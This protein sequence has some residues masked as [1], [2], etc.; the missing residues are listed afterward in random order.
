MRA[1]R[2]CTKHTARSYTSYGLTTAVRVSVCK[3]PD[4]V[5]AAAA[6]LRVAWHSSTEQVGGTRRARVGVL[7]RVWAW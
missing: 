5:A 7:A 2:L 6:G 1:D 3:A 4:A